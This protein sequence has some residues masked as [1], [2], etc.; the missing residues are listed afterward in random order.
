MR[1]GEIFHFSIYEGDDDWKVNTK[2]E[3]KEAL[4]R[5]RGILLRPTIDYL[6]SLINLEFSVVRDYISE[7][8]RQSLSELQIYKRVA[9]YNIYYRALKLFN[10][11]NIPHDFSGINNGLEKLM[12]KVPLDSKRSV[13]VFD[14]NYKRFCFVGDASVPSE[15]QTMNIG[16]V[17]FYQFLESKEMREA[18]LDRVLKKLEGLYDATSLSPY[19]EGIVGGPGDYFYLQN[20]KEIDVYEQ[21]LMALDNKKSLN[22]TDKKLVEVTNQVYRMFME[23]YG[24]TSESFEEVKHV[25][26]YDKSKLQRTLV[27]KQPN[28]TITNNVRYL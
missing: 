25:R 3:L 20:A 12:I 14:F 1:R 28:L 21:K 26:F 18:E 16:D 4:N 19:R 24:L 5:Y 23:D 7:D 8:D 17:S 2:E 15:Y 6:D 22:D 11:K 13:S 27:K 9:I 10:E